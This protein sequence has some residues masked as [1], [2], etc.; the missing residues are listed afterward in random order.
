MGRL[1]RKG[2]ASDAAPNEEDD[3]LKLNIIVVLVA[4]GRVA[5]ASG[6]PIMLGIEPVVLQQPS[7]ANTVIGE[8]P[9][10]DVRIDPGS[11][12]FIEL[13][14]QQRDPAFAGLSCVYSDV[15]YDPGLIDCSGWIPGAAFG[16]FAGY[17]TCDEENGVI[18]E[19][20]GCS[21]SFPGPGIFPEWALVGAARLVA[22]DTGSGMVIST[23]P[24]EAGSSI[25]AYGLVPD[26]TISFGSTLQFAIRESPGDIDLDGDVDPEDA[27]ILGTCLSGPAQH[28]PPSG[29]STDWFAAADLNGDF[30]V[31]ME[32][33]AVL[34]VDFSP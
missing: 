2:G 24:S 4:V 18:D 26:E 29:C 23:S 17:E 3:V 14:A 10:A 33:F 6:G 27:E 31:D 11:T 5:H 22:I 1:Y 34:A 15:S 32:D 9:I 16:I 21:F 7:G 13:W 19:A 30:R 12:F 25:V 8:P 28:A 20:G